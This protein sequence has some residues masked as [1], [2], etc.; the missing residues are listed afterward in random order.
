[1]VKYTYDAW[2]K[3][4]TTVVDSTAT[5]IATLN[6]FRYRSYYFDTE[7]GFYFLKTRYYDPE[8]GRFITIDDLSYLDPDS[9]NGLNLYAY[10]LNNPI[11][12]SDPNGHFVI[13]TTMIIG[14]LIGAVVLGTV[15]GI[16]A[17]Q[18]AVETG[19]TGIDL[20]NA[21]LLGVATGA[22]LGVAVGF[23]ATAGISFLVGGLASVT[24]KFVGDTVSSLLTGTN[25]IGTWE[26]YAIAFVFGGLLKGSSVGRTVKM[27]ADVVV[28]PA[29]DQLVKHQTRGKEFDAKTYVYNV[30][31]RGA[32]YGSSN[33]TLIN[34]NMGAEFTIS[35]EKVIIRGFY[36]AFGKNFVLE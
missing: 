34:Y 35:L 4:Q 6:P 10:C 11:K 21:T 33:Y 5:E 26:S 3:C 15:G 23:V 14:M 28:R 9:I 18:S 32:T 12:Y 29:V 20:L 16:T 17:Y 1:M 2:G 31:L 8:I 25:N 27:I 22:I 36:S 7:T 13:T 19:K 30:L 24:G